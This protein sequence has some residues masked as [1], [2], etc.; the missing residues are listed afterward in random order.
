MP[1]WQ[2]EHAVLGTT[3]ADVGAYLL[4]LWGLPDPIVEAIAYHHCPSNSVDGT[5]TPLTAVHAAGVFVQHQYAECTGESRASLDAVY[6]ARL[7]LEDRVLV[8]QEESAKVVD[9]IAAP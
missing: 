1:I 2:A 5:F 8:W 3:H 7:G 9:E 4:G 6:L